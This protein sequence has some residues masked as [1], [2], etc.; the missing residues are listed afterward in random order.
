MI[1]YFTAKMK[2]FAMLLQN[3]GL[4]MEI[5]TMHVNQIVLIKI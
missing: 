3:C 4:G 1:N 2:L 5:K